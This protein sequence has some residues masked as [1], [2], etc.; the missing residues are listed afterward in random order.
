MPRKGEPLVWLPRDEAVQVE[1]I[2]A[3]LNDRH[4]LMTDH[5]N[6]PAGR[7]HELYDLL[8]NIVVYNPTNPERHQ[9]FWL[10][11]D[12]VHCHPEARFR[13]PYQYLR[14]IEAAYDARYG[15]DPHFARHIHRNPLCLVSD[16]VWLH[17]QAYTLSELAEVVSLTPAAGKRA[18]ARSECVAVGRG[19]N[20]TLFDD[21]RHWAYRQVSDARAVDYDIW[22][23]QVVTRALNLN[24][25]A[26]Q[27]P[28][29][30]SEVYGVAGSVAEYV[31]YRYEP[32]SGSGVPT[33]EF[34]ARQAE[35]GRRGGLVSRG[36]GRPSKSGK[37]A[38]ELI[39]AAVKLKAEGLSNRDIS[40][41]LNIS[42]STVSAYL[43]RANS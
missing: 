34:R 36:G 5:D 29:Q 22:H 11:R 12:P 6:G 7:A 13:K 2:R 17:E 31:Y 10:L 33:P 15:C 24:N 41:E 28:L 42:A 32:G 19:R 1:R 27:G 9:A 16:A 3:H 23:R 38:Q 18:A 25:F 30:A 14:A 21:L 4:Y 35:R 20:C 39:L 37:T 8:P 26:D 43:K 40:D